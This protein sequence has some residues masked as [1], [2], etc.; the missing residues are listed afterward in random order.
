MAKTSLP[1][2]ASERSTAVNSDDSTKSGEYDDTTVWFAVVYTGT[3]AP[4]TNK[5][6]EATD[7]PNEFVLTLEAYAQGNIRGLT[8]SAGAPVVLDQNAVL[9]EV[10]TDYFVLN[11]DD[12]VDVQVYTAA[13]NGNGTY[14]ELVPAKGCTYALYRSRAKISF[15]CNCILRSNYFKR[16]DLKL[17]SIYCMVNIFAFSLY[18]FTLI[19]LIKNTCTG[20]LVFLHHQI[21]NSISVLLIFKNNMFYKTFDTVHINNTF[22]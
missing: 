6:V 22:P 19:K 20:Y 15:Y 2:T 11:P 5:T 17:F 7:D 14:G 21:D 9:R 8:N 10:L 13:Y 18:A 12:Q 1:G 16:T 3:G 4:M